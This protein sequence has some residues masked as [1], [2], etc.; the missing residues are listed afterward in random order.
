[1]S[2]FLSLNIKSEYR[3]LSDDIV[4]EFY[5][6]CL[7]L[8]KIYRRA[9]GFFSSTS[10]AEVSKGI[11][12]LLEN[13]GKI[14][15]I[16]SPNLSEEDMEAIKK[17]YDERK[18]VLNRL[19][20]SLT[21]PSDILQEKRLDMLT[22]LIKYNALDIK[23]ALIKNHGDYGMYHEKLGLLIDEENNKIAF[24]GS[25]NES[26]TA[27]KLNYETIDVFRSW[28]NEYEN[29]RVKNKEESLNYIWENKDSNVVV[30]EYPEINKKILEKYSRLN[31]DY[32]FE[33]KDKIDLEDP[34]RIIGPYMPQSIKLYSYQNEA[35]KKWQ[36]NNYRG[37]YD[38]ATGTGKTLTAL[39]SMVSINSNKSN[40]I[41]TIIICPL[42]HLVEQWT[43]D[44]Q[45]FGVSPIVG[46]SSSNQKNWKKLLKDAIRDKKLGVT[47]KSFFCFICTNA[48]FSSD[49]VQL[50]LSKMPDETLIIVDEAHN[51][52]AEKT[53]NMLPENIKYRLALSATIERYN[54]RAGT[55]SLY[56]Y[57]GEKC[58]EFSLEMAI[59]D[60]KLTEYYYYP[61]YTYFEDDELIQ[62][63]SITRE[64]YEIEKISPSSN[65]LVTLTK[66]MSRLIASSRQRMKH[67]FEKIKPLS[68]DSHM[69]VYCG[70]STLPVASDDNLDVLDY[71][72]RQID[73]VTEYLSTN[74][75]MKVAM[76]TSRENIQEREILKE[77]FS[78][79]DNLQ[80]LVAIKCL[81]EGVNIPSIHTAFIL[82]ST[83]NPKE[84]IQRRGRVLRRCKGKEYA[85]IFD[86]VTLP[87][88]P[89]S[90]HSLTEYELLI[91]QKL[92]ISEF[93]R[94]YEFARIAKNK[95]SLLIELDSM[96][97]S[98][99]INNKEIYNEKTY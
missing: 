79:N 6:P 99:N 80:S 71:E 11:V 45:K 42:Q 72:L 37:I 58:I 59:K 48:T 13:G 89:D 20:S 41:S 74:L 32:S 39:G 82:A 64:I 95:T 28:E 15:L 23:I 55:E 85:F 2:S 43:E 40:R 33:S 57:F 68:N 31:S 3:S 24:S 63:Q 35:I 86:F 76:Y 25:M 7:S 75:G 91:D 70:V 12:N 18:I 1:M 46:Y 22:N 56:E 38:M 5:I 29:N 36:D 34:K 78:S 8:A 54:D 66:N 81:D 60:K 30:Y 87:R 10:I 90:S 62:Y 17:G 19:I 49:F 77:K 93:K 98:Y 9:V 44:I 83:S 47:G 84:Y 51:I 65:K 96:M 53:R 94:V 14:Q 21:E 4:K 61:V 73:Y 69:L 52:G 27:M 26:Y 92:V 67:F 97:S 16:C 50:Q 88:E